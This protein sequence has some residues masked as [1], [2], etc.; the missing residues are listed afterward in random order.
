M[1][2]R[3]GGGPP[4]TGIDLDCP[5]VRIYLAAVDSLTE[6]LLTRDE[7]WEMV[8]RRL[9]ADSREA[10]LETQRARRLAA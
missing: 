3:T 5:Y 9:M 2:A 7:R 4:A 8:A 1:R 10:M 6:A